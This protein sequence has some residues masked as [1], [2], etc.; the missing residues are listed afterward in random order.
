LDI[1]KKNK[2]VLLNFSEEDFIIL[3]PQGKTIPQPKLDDLTSM[4][5]LIPE[6]CHEFYMHL[7]GNSN[8]R[9][10]ILGYGQTI[11]FDLEEDEG[12]NN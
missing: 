11:D 2:G 12:N 7:K 3:W 8:L 9:E 1:S 6:D 5:N 4:F 10:D